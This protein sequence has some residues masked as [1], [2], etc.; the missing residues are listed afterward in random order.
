MPTLR[1]VRATPGQ[2]LAMFVLGAVTV[3][4]CVLGVGFSSSAHLPAGSAGALL[5]LAIVA[6][7]AQ[8]A[9]Y[10]RAHRH[11]VALAQLRGV[12]GPAL[13]WT[14]VAAPVL[15]LGVAAVAG[16]VLAAVGG[17]V[18]ARWWGD[19]GSTFEMAG[20]EWI[21]AAGVLAVT[22]LVVVASS[23]RTTYE[24]LV[25]KLGSHERPHPA[26]TAGLF[27]ILLVAI[28]ALFSAYHARQLGAG[29][30][31][32]TS[33]LS[34]ALVGLTA[35][36][37]GIWLLV[38]ASRLALGSRRLDASVPS[39]L[40]LRRLTR[41]G[42]SVATIRVCTAAVVVAGVAA[43]AWVGA[44][45]WRDQTARIETGG[46]IAYEVPT[47]ALQAYAAS[48]AAD[49]DGRWLMAM[50]A[51]PDPSGGSA[52]DMF[53]DSP[54]WR[55]VVGPFFAGTPVDTVSRGIDALPQ[56][57]PVTTV[58]AKS[59]TVRFPRAS[60]RRALPS[61]R[62]VRRNQRRSGVYG[63]VPIRFSLTYVD[64][65]GDLQAV[66]LPDRDA[67]LP[68]GVGRGVVGY[69][70]SVP[71]CSRACA[72]ETVSVQGRTH[73]RLQ[74]AAMTFGDQQLLG[75]GS[76]ALSPSSRRVG[77]TSVVSQ[78]GLSLRVNDPYDPSP[79]LDWKADGVAQA[80][81]TP[82]V[83]LSTAGGQAQADGV[84]GQSRPVQVAG[85]VPAL[86]LLGRAGLLLDLGTALRGAS[87]Q[88]PDSHK[89][90]VARSDTPPAI[91]KRLAATGAVATK[92]TVSSRLER[93]RRSGSADGIRLYALIAGFGVLICGVSV[94][95]STLGQG[96]ARRTEAASLRVVG[97]SVR[98]LRRSYR[99]EAGW[100]GAAVAVIALA[101]SWICC[102]AVLVALPLIDSGRF[103]LGFDAT[104]PIALLT[105]FAL[106]AGIAFA[107]AVAVTLQPVAAAATPSR[108]RDADR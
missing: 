104:P 39:F 45:R 33:F 59:F 85:Q 107:A 8:A 13:L 94:V 10:V 12:R 100:L 80:L 68:K 97:V 20:D 26:S 83:R 92:S 55:R 78:R 25:R 18:V 66:N 48:H 50:T 51:S 67:S 70:V 43:S 86:P 19:A 102:S 3:L 89:V 34:P 79:L 42:G 17:P 5:L 74:V 91:L 108:L 93:I 77:V 9:A 65:Q 84:D 16:S 72:V 61:R 96:H 101:A 69:S 22:V 29:R 41:Q 44:E 57:Q 30:A 82:G 6:V 36:Q 14:A 99:I 24:P 11:D 56:G 4:G 62:E 7:A 35:G 53:V 58:R 32:W 31:D 98:A 1:S 38:V 23:W 106:G 87:G 60:A 52:R 105:G 73:G 2:S 47:G 28:G 46:Q 76:G 40:A 49:P 95:S 88:I 63:Y 81:A 27:L 71:G 15:L 64:D 90:I 103:G 37:I 21:T 54:R 75:G